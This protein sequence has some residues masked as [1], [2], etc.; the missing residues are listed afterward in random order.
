MALLKQITQDDGVITDYHRILFLNF[1]VNSHISIAVLSYAN[2]TAR[3]NEK[4]KVIAQPY[5]RSVTYETPYDESMT[6]ETA[7]DYLK[8]LPCFEGAEDV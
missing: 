1:M 3:S 8:T 6:I 4:N 7:Y 5:K 2:E